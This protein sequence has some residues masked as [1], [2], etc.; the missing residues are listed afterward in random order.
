MLFM[1]FISIHVNHVNSCYSCQFMS[2]MSIHV[3]S[4][5][6]S[7]KFSKVGE[8]GRVKYVFLGLRRQLRCQAKG[9]KEAAKKVFFATNVPHCHKRRNASIVIK[10]KLFRYAVRRMQRGR[11]WRKNERRFRLTM[12]RLAARPAVR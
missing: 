3:N 2:L 11:S 8:G 6:V 4:C 5:H 1:S 10:M 7:W 12:S 9:K